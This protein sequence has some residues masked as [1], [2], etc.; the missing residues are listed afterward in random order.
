M[1]KVIPVLFIVLIISLL[2]CGPSGDAPQSSTTTNSMGSA[3]VRRQARRSR[4]HESERASSR[5][6][7]H[8][9]GASNADA[10]SGAPGSPE[11]LPDPSRKIAK[12]ASLTI[13][14][15]NFDASYKRLLTLVKGVSGAYIS[16]SNAKK[17][18]NGYQYG[19]MVIR[20]PSPSFDMLFEGLKEVG[21]TKKQNITSVDFTKTYYD[22]EARLQT[23]ESY[24]TRLLEIMKTRAKTYDEVQDAHR[25]L[26]QVQG[27]IDRIKGQMK[28]INSVSEY[29]TI[30]LHFKENEARRRGSFSRLTTRYGTAFKSGVYN[31]L[32]ILSFIIEYIL[33]LSLLIALFILGY[34]LTKKYLNKKNKES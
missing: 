15:K 3:D 5:N 23:K 33:S 21:E 30:T 19:I 10:S 22:L 31:T 1:K 17:E 7:R 32:N 2:S 29:S 24:K 28:Y 4:L 12:N 34:F 20:V 18:E 25:R 9:G 8:L 26:M 6:R 16:S 13:E 27:A 11:V 14:V